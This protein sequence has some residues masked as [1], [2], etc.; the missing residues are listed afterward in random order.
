MFPSC[1]SKHRP[2]WEKWGKKE[3]KLKWED[4]NVSKVL[5]QTQAQVEKVGKKVGGGKK[6]PSP[7]TGGNSG[8]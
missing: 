2:R 5:L 3:E 7:L 6:K 1:C 4:Q 8:K